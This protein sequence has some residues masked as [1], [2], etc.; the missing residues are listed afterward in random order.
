LRAFWR[1]LTATGALAAAI[2]LIAEWRLGNGTGKDWLYSVSFGAEAIGVPLVAITEWS[3]ALET[4]KRLWRRSMS[5]LKG[6]G[7]AAK[8]RSRTAWRAIKRRLGLQVSGTVYGVTATAT[9]RVTASSSAQVIR[10]PFDKSAPLPEQLEYLGS[11]VE[12][13][14]AIVDPMQEE[15]LRGIKST[16]D[17]LRGELAEAVQEVRLERLAERRAGMVLLLLGVIVG[18]IGNLL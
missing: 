13:L 6:R 7:R 17:T 4:L 14:M 3:G 8:R 16:G 1:I 2:A 5:L 10:V 15:W 11:R 12:M 9:A 18:A